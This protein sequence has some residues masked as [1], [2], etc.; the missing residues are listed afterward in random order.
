MKR[1]DFA[2]L[3][4]GLAVSL[5]L[6]S[7]AQQTPKLPRIGLLLYGSLSASGY[8]VDGGHPFFV[9]LREAGLIDG[10]NVIIIVRGADGH[11]E[12]LP[13]LA[14]ELVAANSDV[15]VTAGPQPVQAA[16]DATATIPI[17]M[18]IVSDPVT[19]GFVANLAHPGGNMTGLSMLNTELSS[20]RIEFLREA[21]P[22]I[23]RVAVFTDPSMGPQGLPET[24][25]AAHALGLELQI[26]KLAPAQVLDGSAEA[27]LGEAQALLVMPTPFYNLPAVRK[28]IGEMAQRLHLPSMCEEVSFVRDGCLLSYGPDFAAMWQRSAVYVD[29][30]L[31]G[32]KPADLP[33]EQPT[34]FNLFVNAATAKALGLT[35]PQSIL[36]RADELIE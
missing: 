20:K 9:G 33:V 11:T 31:K 36:T 18:A 4:A 29:K 34:K 28:R 15:I 30:I 22:A 13:Q 2:A 3:L 21:A 27:E 19:Y 25:A 17:V 23:T 1:R 10:R 12:R 16:K 32:A 26:I 5:P 35:V 24:A 7:R 14:H 8:Q 6:S